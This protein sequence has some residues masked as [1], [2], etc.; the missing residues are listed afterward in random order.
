M[1]LILSNDAFLVEEA[2][3]NI[4]YVNIVRSPKEETLKKR[5]RKRLRDAGIDARIMEVRER[6]RVS[7]G[8]GLKAARRIHVE[9]ND[10]KGSD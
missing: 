2:G 6:C 3:E 4:V 5:V 9:V 10:G 1:A 8:K 7:F